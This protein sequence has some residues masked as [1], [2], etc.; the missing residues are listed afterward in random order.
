M[1]QHRRQRREEKLLPAKGDAVREDTFRQTI[2]TNKHNGNDSAGAINVK[3]NV[4]ARYGGTT[5]GKVVPE[6]SANKNIT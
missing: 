1:N 3:T 5:Q 2:T 4:S 6:L